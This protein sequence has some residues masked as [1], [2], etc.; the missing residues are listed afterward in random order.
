ME[1][2]RSRALASAEI[3]H[4]THRYAMA[5]LLRT[6]NARAPTVGTAATPRRIKIQG[7]SPECSSLLSMV[8]K[9]VSGDQSDQLPWLSCCLK[10]Q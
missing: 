6:K 3:H 8:V 5:L 1:C 7:G 10:R 9:E 4:A 2:C